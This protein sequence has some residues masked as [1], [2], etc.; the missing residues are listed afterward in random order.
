MIVHTCI[1]ACSLSSGK[2]KELESLCITKRLILWLC[3]KTKS[4]KVTYQIVRI[5]TKTKQKCYVADLVVF[6]K[7]FLA[8]FLL[9]HVTM[10]YF[11]KMQKLLIG[12]SYILLFLQFTLMKD[13]IH[14]SAGLA[15]LMFIY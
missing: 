3:S 12:Q 11:I 15:L 9:V 2:L 10:D 8:R 13:C 4:M 7:K 14:G 6:R 1:P 5:Q